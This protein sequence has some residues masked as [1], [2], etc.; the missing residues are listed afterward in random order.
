MLLMRRPLLAALGFSIAAWPR[1]V[2][3]G[4]EAQFCIAAH[5]D[6]QILKDQRKL[7]E[8]SRRFT[9]CMAEVCPNVVREDCSE[10]LRDTE[11]ATPSVVLS[12]LDA[13][14]RD[15]T[16]ISAKIDGRLLTN[17][18]DALPVALD[19]GTHTIEFTARDG[20]ARTVTVTLREA[21]KNQRVLA[22]FRVTPNTLVAAPADSTPAAS[23][24]PPVLAYV[25]G[26]VGLVALGSFAYFATSGHAIENELDQCKPNCQG[27]EDR[28]SSMRTR[29]VIGDVSLALAL[30]SL[31]AGTYLWLAP[32]A[33]P[34]APSAFG[35]GVSGQF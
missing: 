23:S 22:D 28:I 29:Y 2:H 27:K 32:P 3:A 11:L 19:P 15:T 18:L 33:A 5:A 6:G 7:V 13:Q 1:V 35:A 25:L 20:S 8:A 14:G 16:Q 34:G 30:V 17:E 4:P 12:G 9:S 21:Q 24:K 10:F 31:G 26:G